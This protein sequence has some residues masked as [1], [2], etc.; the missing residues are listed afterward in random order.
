MNLPKPASLLKK[1]TPP[2]IWEGFRNRLFGLKVVP[3]WPEVSTGGWHNA[4]L[5]VEKGYEDGSHRMLDGA[6]VGFLL[7]EEFVSDGNVKEMHD[8][9]IQFALVV[10]RTAVGRSGLRILDFGGGLGIHA[11]AIKRLLPS[12]QF[13]YTV[14]ELA[15]IADIGKHKNTAVRFISTLEEAGNVYELIY[16]SSS[17]QYVRDWRGLVANLCKK[18]ECNIFITRTPFVFNGP[19]FVT[20][21][22]AYHTEYP[23]W[24]FNYNEVVQEFL[25]YGVKLK[26]VFINGRGIAVARH[27]EPNIHLGLLFEKR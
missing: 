20:L 8:R 13:D 11:L 9:L 12:V 19:T 2:I 18:S 14:C 17:I 22:R 15:E 25:R 6:A 27:S 23:G 1:V 24:V 21:Q 10:A 16:A 4:G 7:K 5:G 3:D 26:E